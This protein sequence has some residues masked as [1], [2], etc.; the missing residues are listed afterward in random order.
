MTYPITS[1]LQMWY[2][3]HM[4]I[5]THYAIFLDHGFLIWLPNDYAAIASYVCEIYIH[6]RFLTILQEEVTAIALLKLLPFNFPIV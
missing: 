5:S 3:L 2:Y 4:A 1:L 6:K